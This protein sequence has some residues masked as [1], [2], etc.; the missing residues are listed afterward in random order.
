MFFKKIFDKTNNKILQ[1]QSN[2]EIDTT[3]SNLL[4]KKDENN[5]WPRK[6]TRP[7]TSLLPQRWWDWGVDKILKFLINIQISG[8]KG[9]EWTMLFFPPLTE[10]RWK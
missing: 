4:K 10:K 5:W 9:T 3:E 2:A 7:K 8:K 1:Q 6:E